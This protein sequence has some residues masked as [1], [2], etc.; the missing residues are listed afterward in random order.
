MRESNIFGGRRILL[1]EDD[2]FV[3]M[4]M[5]Q[6]LEKS[7]AQVIGPVP[8]VEKA[9]DRIEKLSGITGA[10]L[11]INLQGELVFPVADELSKRRIPFVFASGYDAATIPHRFADVTLIQKPTSVE[12]IAEVLFG[13]EFCSDC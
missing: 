2:Y 1:A 3:V 9:L 11:D 10:I 12:R 4:Q 5:V 7:G 8:S 13:S 6:D